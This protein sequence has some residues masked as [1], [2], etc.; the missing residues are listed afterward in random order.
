MMRTSKPDARRLPP[1]AQEDLR[2]RVIRAVVEDGMKQVEA[3]RVFGV[4]RGSIDTW[5]RAYGIQRGGGAQGPQAGPQS[6]QPTPGCSD[7]P[8]VVRVMFGGS[9]G[10]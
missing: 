5:L 10:R 7:P 4:S 1:E 6:V 8:T 3:V 2:R 9:R